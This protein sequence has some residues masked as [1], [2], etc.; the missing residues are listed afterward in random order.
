MNFLAKKITLFFIHRKQIDTDEYE[1]YVYCFEVLL[2]SIFN[3][4]ILIIGVLISRLYIETLIFVAV[5]IISR[6]FCGGFHAKT[7]WGCLLLLIANYTIF[8]LSFY[9]IGENILSIISLVLSI[10][11]IPPII[12]YAPVSHPNNPLPQ[13]RVK[14]F[15]HFAAMIAVFLLILNV[16]SI[17]SDF[18]RMGF[19]WTFPFFCVVIAMIVG[20]KCYKV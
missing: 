16:L 5:F 2:S 13:K 17:V 10:T 8:S 12:L 15:K 18:T 4:I 9:L 3:A 7:H 20:K 1:V 19:V 14:I 6:K 11:L